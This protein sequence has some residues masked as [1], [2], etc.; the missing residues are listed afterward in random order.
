MKYFA[1][2]LNMVQKDM[3]RRCPGAELLGTALLLDTVYEFRG[4]A[5]VRRAWGSEI[6]SHPVVPVA[7]WEINA[8]H[9]RALDMF[10]G[11]PTYYRKEIWTAV[12]PDGSEIEGMIYLMNAADGMNPIAPASTWY[13]TAVLHAYY[14]L[15]LKEYI[16]VLDQA[17]Q[18]AQEAENEEH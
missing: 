15:G 8:E 9:E 16:S 11:W 13:Y 6:D 18:H 7:V 3:A 14:D 12:M 5:T 2:G 17:E 4:C 1:Y 10:E